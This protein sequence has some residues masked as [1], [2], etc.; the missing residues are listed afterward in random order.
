[1]TKENFQKIKE[2]IKEAANIVKELPKT[3]QPKAFE[4]IIESLLNKT[5]EENIINNNVEIKSSSIDTKEEKLT[6]LAKKL[7]VNDKKVLQTIYNFSKKG[8]NLI[9]RLEGKNAKIQQQ[10]AY[11]YLFVKLVCEEQEWVPTSKLSEQVK[12]HGVNDGHMAQ[13]LR[14]EKGKIL[15]SGSG[16]GLKYGLSIRGINESKIILKNLISQK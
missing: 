12:K 14:K 13:N 9:V 3:I 8:I 15:I 1:M 10:I 5:E 6:I 4:V 2:I 16:K 7:H 11:L